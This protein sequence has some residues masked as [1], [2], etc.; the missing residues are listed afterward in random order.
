MNILTGKI[1]WNR[2][3]KN[4]IHYNG[5]FD[6]GLLCLHTQRIHVFDFDKKASFYND[7]TCVFCSIIGYISNLG[8]IR[9]KYALNDNA[10]VVVIEKSQDVI[11]LVGAHLKDRYGFKITIINADAFV[12]KP[13]TGMKFDAVWHDVW[14]NLCTDNLVEMHRLHRKY[15]KRCD[16]QGSWGR[17]LC[18][19]QAKLGNMRRW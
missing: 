10:D 12:Y 18:E 4:K 2:Y 14:D 7:N 15:G 8:K 6:N 16:W 9:T 1:V 13:S 19:R 3:Q 17:E 11:N 5:D